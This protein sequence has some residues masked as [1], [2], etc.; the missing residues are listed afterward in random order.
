M[1]MQVPLSWIVTEAP[2]TEPVALADAKAHLR[3]SGTASDAVITALLASA[4]EYCELASRR[5]FVE[6][7]ITARFQFIPPEGAWLPQGPV[8]SV[9]SVSYLDGDGGTIAL[10][11]STN[12]TKDLVRLTPNQEYARTTTLPDPYEVVFT[13]GY[14][15]VPDRYKQAILLIAGHWFENR[16]EVT[17]ITL[18]EIPMG[19]KMLLAIDRNN[20]YAF[21]DG[22]S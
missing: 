6:R 20:N 2:A 15:T 11:Y 16:E 4:R 21:G 18:A 7:E 8:A 3:V 5:C 12:L 14:S 1:A 9:D 10:T 22:G 13:A 17:D 19:A